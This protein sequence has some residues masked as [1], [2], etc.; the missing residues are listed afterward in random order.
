MNARLKRLE[1]ALFMERN[2]ARRAHLERTLEIDLG[3]VAL[4][5]T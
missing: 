4:P 3:P 1:F 2:Y 5:L